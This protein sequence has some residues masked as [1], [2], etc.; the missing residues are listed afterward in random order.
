MN[1]LPCN[2]LDNGSDV[3]VPVPEKKTTSGLWVDVLAIRTRSVVSESVSL[4]RSP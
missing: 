2:F 1:A 3:F 4:F